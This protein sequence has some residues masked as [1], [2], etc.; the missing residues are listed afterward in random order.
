MALFQISPRCGGRG[1][2]R[3][4]KQPGAS[5]VA[6]ALAIVA[7]PLTLGC[8][9]GPSRVDAPD[10]DSAD[11]AENVVS[12][13]DKNGDGA[14]DVEEIASAPGLADGLKFVDTDSDGK[15]TAAEVEARFDKFIAMK[16]GI[17][18]S[19]FRITYKGRPVANAE[20]RFI[21]ES[22]LTDLIGP[23]SGTTDETGVVAPITEGQTL[24]GMSPGYYRVQIATGGGNIPEAYRAESSPLGVD[25]TLTD[26]ASRYQ[27]PELKIT[28]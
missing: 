20:V 5:V 23:A 7:I 21:P 27:M 11:I 22:Y 3:A 14:V 8:G 26:D 19:K 28:D 15:V 16:V 4:I 10:W 2:A 25:A 9:S 18:D 6:A 17:R 24:P 1:C 13:L 12:T